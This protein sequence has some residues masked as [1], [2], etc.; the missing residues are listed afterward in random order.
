MKSKKFTLIELLV[1]IAI[2]AILAAMLLPALN[3][4]R[5]RARAIHCLNNIKQLGLA[6][7]MYTDE[8]GFY[9]RRGAGGSDSVWYSQLIGI[10]IGANVKVSSGKP[11]F[12]PTDTIDL[13]KCPSDQSPMFSTVASDLPIAGAGGL[14]YTTN[15]RLSGGVTIGTV[16]YGLA[17]TVVNKPS[18]ILWLT[19][20]NSA[21]GVAYYSFGRVSY[22]HPTINGSPKL[23]GAGD[24]IEPTGN[25]KGMGINVAWADGHASSEHEVINYKI[26][27]TTSPW[28]TR[29]LP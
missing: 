8:S 16:L 1:V 2:I 17:A 10:Y 11:S 25:T 4:A 13:F 19:E 12:S 18:S 29:W 6:S 20:G 14:S 21:T 26:G 22:R 3:K 15:T 24:N 28:S 5:E 7:A 9:P 23:L 27:N